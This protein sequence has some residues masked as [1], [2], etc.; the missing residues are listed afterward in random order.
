[1]ASAQFAIKLG[2]WDHRKIRI[3]I[4]KLQTVYYKKNKRPCEMSQIIYYML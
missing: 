2:A 4:R 1:M 3:T